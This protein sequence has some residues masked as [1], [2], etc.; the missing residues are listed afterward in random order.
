MR[1]LLF[2]LLAL[3]LM[4]PAQETAPTLRTTTNEVLL[5]FVVR[6]KHA[7]TIKDLRPDEVQVFEDGVLQP[8]RHFEFLNGHSAQEVAPAPA[9]AST[10]SS[11]DNAPAEGHTV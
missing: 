1:N 3:P 11:S 6:D 5:D 9:A 2:V 10:G 8:L 4:A 7:N